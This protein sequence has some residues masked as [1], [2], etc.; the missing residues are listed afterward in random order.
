MPFPSAC[1]TWLFSLSFLGGDQEN[2]WYEIL[3]FAPKESVL[4][5]YLHLH[6]LIVLDWLFW[7]NGSLSFEKENDA[8]T[9]IGTM[10]SHPL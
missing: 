6:T 4:A 8:L 1:A 7:S 10:I 3:S 2:A 9:N 5:G